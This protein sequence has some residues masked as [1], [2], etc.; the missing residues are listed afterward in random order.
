MSFVWVANQTKGVAEKTEVG[1][2]RRGNDGMVEILSGLEVGSRLISSGLEG[3][4]SG[5]RIKVIGES[6]SD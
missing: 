2:G 5:N 1:L 6:I 3:L 4:A